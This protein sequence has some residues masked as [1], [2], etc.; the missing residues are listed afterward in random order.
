MNTLTKAATNEYASLELHKTYD[1]AE[2]YLV[3]GTTTAVLKATKHFI[4]QNAFEALFTKLSEPLKANNIDKL[5]FDK[6]NL[7]VFSQPSME[8]YYTSWKGQMAEAG[9][10]KHR[11]MLPQD[12]LFRTSVEIGRQNIRA[13]H[14]HIAAHDLDIQYM[15]TLE[16]A[17][18]K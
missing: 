18:E 11:K 10:T 8:W 13:K 14:P 3:P 9:L 7:T 12:R 17:I 4:P 15:D 5:V 2:L 1:H 6:R 16:M